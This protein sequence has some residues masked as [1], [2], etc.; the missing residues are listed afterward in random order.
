MKTSLLL[1]LPVLAALVL[2]GCSDKAKPANVPPP[3]SPQVNAATVP[4]TPSLSQRAENA[5]DKGKAAA[6]DAKDAISAK[7]TEWKL[8][9]ADIKSDFEKTGRVVREKTLTAG[10][11]VG[12]VIDNARLVTVI[13]GKYVTDPDLSARKINVDANAG[14]VTLTGSVG[15]LDLVG[16]A[17][18][19]ALDTAGVTQVVGLL[20][21][22]DPTAGET[23]PGKM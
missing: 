17:V 9:P 5:V 18:L 2:A 7:L 12:G 1:P 14:V 23:A 22:Q 8:T 19:L 10:E 21:I 15:S 13:N 6:A 3:S 20:T 16:R 4:T 11:K